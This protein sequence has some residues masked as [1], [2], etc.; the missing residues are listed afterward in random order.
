MN[1]KTKTCLRRFLAL[2]LIFVLALGCAPLPTVTTE[3]LAADGEEVGS[4]IKTNGLG[5]VKGYEWHRVNK[6][7]DL[8][9]AGTRC[10]VL[11]LWKYDN[12]IYYADGG[13]ACKKE[14]EDAVKSGTWTVG[15]NGMPNP[16][17]GKYTDTLSFFTTDVMTSWTM[18][19]TG[20][21][22]DDNQDAPQVRFYP[23]EYCLLTGWDDFDFP[24]KETDSHDH[25]S[26]HTSDLRG[27]YGDSISAGKVKI[28]CNVKYDD[29]GFMYKDECLYGLCS[30]TYKYDTFIMYWGEERNITAITD[31][32]LIAEGQVMNVDDGV[33]LMED[34]T[35]VVEPGGVL[36]IEGTFYN[37]GTIENRG[38]VI[39]QENACVCCSPKVNASA[40]RILCSGSAV[41]LKDYAD[42]RI[43]QDEAQIEE[44]LDLVGTERDEYEYNRYRG[45]LLNARKSM[46][47]ACGLMEN[48]IQEEERALESLADLKDRLDL[49]EQ[50]YEEYKAKGMDVTKLEEEIKDLWAE[51]KEA[52]EP[53]AEVLAEYASYKGE[54]DRLNEEIDAC[55]A[56]LEWLRADIEKYRTVSGE[57]VLGEGNMIMLKDSKL[58]IGDGTGAAFLVE[59]G[60]N[61]V[62]NGY[63]ISPHEVLLNNAKLKICRDGALIANFRF[64]DGLTGVPFLKAQDPGTTDVTFDGLKACVYP[65]EFAAVGITKSDWVLEVDGIMVSG[66]T[67][68][69]RLKPPSPCKLSEIT[70]MPVSPNYGSGQCV[71]RTDKK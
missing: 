23:N 26:I 13:Y 44:L 11:I 67:Y 48:R 66:S 12:T 14:K 27:K 28:Y 54:L 61:V 36:S 40:G 24:S 37:N 51:Y 34:K 71:L 9:K 6:K 47:S 64:A 19:I 55:N 41:S 49:L 60:A 20:D 58:V 2:A 53:H 62:C 35:L 18:Y 46:Q 3:A 52:Y 29:T 42:I 22:D 5:I 68:V 59:N 63:I 38:T 70:G 45:S 4:G 32:T 31:D 43:Q 16:F 69:A 56:S 15:A 57:P 50:D 17:A 65:M 39:L 8:P 25:W 10:P 21:E 1:D 33:M 7:G 30:N